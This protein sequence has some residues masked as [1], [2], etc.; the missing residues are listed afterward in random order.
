MKEQY[1][2]ILKPLSLPFE[3]V[4]QCGYFS[5]TGEKDSPHIKNLGILVGNPNPLPHLSLSLRKLKNIPGQGFKEK[6]YKMHRKLEFYFIMATNGNTSSNCS[7]K[8][9]TRLLGCADEYHF[10]FPYQNSTQF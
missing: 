3:V 8:P 1:L 9:N 4:Y 2:D 6:E 7:F 10:Y 5:N